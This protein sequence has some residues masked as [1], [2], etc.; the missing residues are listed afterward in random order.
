MN[1]GC[2]LLGVRVGMLGQMSGELVGRV[3]KVKIPSFCLNIKEGI[4]FRFARNF[5]D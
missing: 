3:V 1:K 5:G 2:V 4:M